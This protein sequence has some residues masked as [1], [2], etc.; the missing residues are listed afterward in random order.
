MAHSQREKGFSGVAFSHCFIIPS[1]N[2]GQFIAATIESLLN[3]DD[4]CSEI[5]IS[6]DYSSDN[7]LEIAQFYV[8]KYPDRIRLTRPPVHQGMFPNWNWAISQARTEWISI[9]GSDDQALPNFV[10]TIR[11]GIAK[12]SNVVVVGANWHF[13]DG[14]DNLLFTEKMLSLPEVMHPP[15]T[16][17]KQLFAN[18]V[19]PAAH[20]FRRDAWEKVGGIPAETKLYGDWAL[21]LLMTPLGDF[22]HMRRV[23]ARY[24]IN[25]RPGLELVRMNQN[26]QDEITVR[27]DLIPRI[28]RQFPRV[29]HWRLRL[30]SRRRF[31][32]M[33]NRIHLD[34]A[35]ADPS[36][37]VK[38][39][40]PW[41]RELGPRAL[42]LL[43]R[44][45]RSEPTGVGWFDSAVIQ[46]LREIYKTFQPS[47]PPPP[48]AGTGRNDE[49][50][51]D[52]GRGARAAPARLSV[53]V[54]IEEE[55]TRWAETLTSALAQTTPCDIVAVVR[56]DALAAR[57]RATAPRA[58]VVVAGQGVEELASDGIEAASGDWIVVARPG[59]HLD[60]SLSN[61]VT[62]LA[63][64]RP[65]AVA[66]VAREGAG[67]WLDDFLGTI[68]RS[69]D[70]PLAYA[71]A[72]SA[73]RTVGGYQPEIRALA[74][75][76][77][78]LKLSMQGPCASGLV[79]G[80]SPTIVPGH[81]DCLAD[82]EFVHR[83]LVPTL[84]A[85]RGGV[86]R[87]P[88]DR[89]SRRAFRKLARSTLG[90]SDADRGR[91]ADLLSDWGE[92][93]GECDVLAN[94]RAGRPVALHRPL[95]RLKRQCRSFCRALR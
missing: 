12:T 41:A 63:A 93:L 18:R 80:T 27:F 28:A 38:I 44:F 91:T 84:A 59:A 56:S 62:E 6:E 67:I 16:F 48:S 60:S 77:L 45:A 7:S 17:Y 14:N 81:W 30:A 49:G 29:A 72:K 55:D 37:Q 83:L 87:V 71:F 35:G 34:L 24:R 70:E 90:L 92:R 42:R 54:P 85:R 94:L 57:I 15:Q 53:V 31:R 64:S 88:L 89:I 76:A 69:F 19:H 86:A 2:Q 58:R 50:R 1:H 20:A 21:W 13:V 33:M 43:D 68:L 32:H 47:S 22:V 73:W 9:M 51:N 78:L 46:P 26:L 36:E 66:L 11:E 52:E 65:G 79:I 25:Y 23:I 40:E 61:A 5:L 10:S 39:F 74:D 95:N 4:P 75:R 3:Q 82:T 8:A